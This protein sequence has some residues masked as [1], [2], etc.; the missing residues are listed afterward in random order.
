MKK[1]KPK[2]YRFIY[3][4]LNPILPNNFLGVGLKWRVALTLIGTEFHE[5][6]LLKNKGKL[7]KHFSPTSALQIEL[8]NLLDKSFIKGRPRILDVGA[9]PIS[10]VGKIYDG[11]K[12]ELVAIDPVA[13][14]YA[15]I[16]NNL[17]LKPIVST[18]PGYGE[19][20]TKQFLLNSFDLIHARNCIDHTKN[21][22]LVITEALAVLKPGGYFYL[23]HYINEGE[24]ADYYGLHQWNFFEENNMFYVSNRKN[25]TKIC[26]DS[27]LKSVAI[28][29]SLQIIKDR[30]I[31]IIKKHSNATQELQ[32]LDPAS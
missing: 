7:A 16:L 5:V 26:I 8:C 22:I 18:Q 14:R 31:V 9:G 12:V 19:K 13:V 21:P 25:K 32:L 2:L 24:A 1:L 11:N 29:E 23:N 27:T 28:V 10:K 3:K 4:Y 20:L 15:K 17:N 6:N 30:I